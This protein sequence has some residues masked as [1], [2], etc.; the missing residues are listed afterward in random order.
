MNDRE[1][2]RMKDRTEAQTSERLKKEREDEG[3]RAN[4][5]NRG[6]GLKDHKA[7]WQQASDKTDGQ[8]D[9]KAEGWT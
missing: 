1:K 7:H 4:P 5:R 8:R 2:G 3:E 9:G 6:V